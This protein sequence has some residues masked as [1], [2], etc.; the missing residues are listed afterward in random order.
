[1]GD[2]AWLHEKIGRVLDGLARIADIAKDPET[3]AWYRRNLR[4]HLRPA[5]SDGLKVFLW[6]ADRGGSWTPDAARKP[7]EHGTLGLASLLHEIG[8]AHTVDVGEPS[9]DDDNDRGTRPDEPR[10]ATPNP[11]D[12]PLRR[13]AIAF[14]VYSMA[15]AKM[16]AGEA[17]LLAYITHR[18]C[19]SE[20]V[21]TAV[22]LR[23]FLFSD[24]QLSEAEGEHALDHLVTQRIVHVDRD[25]SDELRIAIRLVAPDV[26]EPRHEPLTH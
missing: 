1:M 11:W 22:M 5:L 3:P 16:P 19:R 12:S 18:V 4:R 25:L 10:I 15:D 7:T 6:S 23:E 21:D 26:N 9:A 24:V 20:Y 2:T 17:R 13:S 8:V 14:A